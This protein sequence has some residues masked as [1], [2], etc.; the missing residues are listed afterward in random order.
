MNT[1]LE[2]LPEMER[3][4]DREAAL[5]ATGYRTRKWSYHDLRQHIQGVAKELS[6][7]CRRGRCPLSAGVAVEPDQR[8]P[9]VLTTRIHSRLDDLDDRH[10]ITSWVFQIAGR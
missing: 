2:L 5:V 10:R 8:G 4:G 3:L 1:L 7:R 6:Q 9:A